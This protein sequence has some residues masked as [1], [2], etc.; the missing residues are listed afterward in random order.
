METTEINNLS[1]QLKDKTKNENCWSFV[2]KAKKKQPIGL[3]SGRCE[4][5][6]IPL[7]EVMHSLGWWHE[8]QRFAY[9]D[10]LFYF[11]YL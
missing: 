3:E 7:H 8:Q 11:I 5:S 1:I 6:Y 2:G 9:F 4:R 10:P